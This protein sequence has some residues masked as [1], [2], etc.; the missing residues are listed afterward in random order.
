VCYVNI[1][2]VKLLFKL[3]YIY[4][5]GGIYNGGDD[6]NLLTNELWLPLWVNPSGYGSGIKRWCNG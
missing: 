1:D 6:E 4:F 5:I 3:N 2:V